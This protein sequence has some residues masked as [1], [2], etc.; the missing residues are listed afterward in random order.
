MTEVWF[1]WALSVVDDTARVIHWSYVKEQAEYFM[2]TFATPDVLYIE[3]KEF[4]N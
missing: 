3:K 4:L 1:V 2:A